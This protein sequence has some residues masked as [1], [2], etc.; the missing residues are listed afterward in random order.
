MNELPKTADK[1]EL[2]LYF[3]KEIASRLYFGSAIPSYLVEK[4]HKELKLSGNIHDWFKSH[5]LKIE[6]LEESRGSQKKKRKIV[7]IT[8]Q[9]GSMKKK[10]QRS[11]KIA[12]RGP[13]I[14]MSLSEIYEEGRR[15]IN[16]QA[17]DQ[18]GR[19]KLK[20]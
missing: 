18:M 20:K 7:K 12:E 1:I 11:S 3:L 17:L 15:P 4:W 2:E 9:G 16:R 13:S 19:K 14:K 5:E 10:R 6:V 8:G